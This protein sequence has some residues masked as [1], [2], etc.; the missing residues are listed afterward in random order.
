MAVRV[1]IVQFAVSGNTLI[2]IDSRPQDLLYKVGFVCTIYHP[3]AQIFQG[4]QPVGIREFL[5][6]MFQS[7]EEF[8]SQAGN[9]HLVTLGSFQLEDCWTSVSGRSY[10]KFSDVVLSFFLYVKSG[11][12]SFFHPLFSILL[13]DCQMLLQ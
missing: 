4:F 10:T 2:F 8:F 3:L 12:L 7:P 1:G 5:S 11:V 9:I 13:E 6:G